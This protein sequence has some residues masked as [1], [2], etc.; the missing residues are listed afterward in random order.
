[1]S[2]NKASGDTILALGS[3]SFSLKEEATPGDSISLQTV[4]SLRAPTM[5]A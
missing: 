3:L 4:M 5:V 1:M 2:F